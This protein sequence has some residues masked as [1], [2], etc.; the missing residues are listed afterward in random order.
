MF[1]H[2]HKS[3]TNPSGDGYVAL[4]HGG[5]VDIKFTNQGVKYRGL[6]I[7]QRWKNGTSAG[8]SGIKVYV[9][10]GT[11]ISDDPLDAGIKYATKDDTVTPQPDMAQP[12]L[13]APA[14][15]TPI[16]YLTPVDL[17]LVFQFKHC[18]LR[19]ESLDAT[20]DGEIMVW[21]DEL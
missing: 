5:A 9:M 14:N 4:L 18:W 21:G 2:T 1:V 20:L 16:E 7:G 8:A 12:P 19:I 13:G 17:N 6:M 15:P 11:G 10:A 3:F